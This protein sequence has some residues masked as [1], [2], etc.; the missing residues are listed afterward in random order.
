MFKK[1]LRD[2]RRA[3]RFIPDRKWTYHLTVRGQ[4]FIQYMMQGHIVGRIVYGFIFMLL[5]VAAI[6]V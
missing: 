1:E 4:I 2:I 6:L 5:F 3:V